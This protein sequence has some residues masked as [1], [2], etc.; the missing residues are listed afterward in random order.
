MLQGLKK[1]KNK[2]YSIAVAKTDKTSLIC[3]IPIIDVEKSKSLLFVKRSLSY[4][5]AGVDSELFYK[6]NTLM[7]FADAKKMV[8]EISKS[9]D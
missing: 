4:G 9:L 2:H 7:L 6:D 1:I 5:Y 8:E 3:G